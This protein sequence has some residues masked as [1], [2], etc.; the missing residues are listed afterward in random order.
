MTKKE[1]ILQ[2]I[3]QLDCSEGIDT[4]TLASLI[5][6]SRAN[7]S[8]ELNDLCKEGKLCKSNG[9]PV[10]FYLADNKKE[11]AKSQLDILAENNISFLPIYTPL[12]Y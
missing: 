2:K 11:T 8:H 4:K 5:N 6:M 10:L 7:L 1:L 9:R 12:I 3:I